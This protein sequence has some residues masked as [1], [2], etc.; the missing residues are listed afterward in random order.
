MVYLED[1]YYLNPLGINMQKLVV[2]FSFTLIFFGCTNAGTDK[3]TD[4]VGIGEIS[5]SADESLQPVVSAL[6]GAFENR[7]SAAKINVI[8]KPEQ[9]SINLLLLD[10]ARV[11]VVTRELNASEKKVFEQQ[12]LKYR[13]LKVGV[14]AVAL[15]TN[16]SSSDTLITFNQLKNMF[17]GKDKSK[18]LVVDDANSSN[19]VCVMDRLGLK[20]VTKL[21]VFSGQSNKGVIEYVKA[22][23]NAIGLIG[24]NWISDGD[25]PAS[26]GFYSDINVM[27]VSA[28]ENPKKE[29]YY[30]PFEYNLYLERYPFRRNIYMIT[31]EARQGLGTG[32][33]NF[34]ADDI[35]QLVIQKTGILPATQPLRLYKVQN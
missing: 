18:I 26:M 29:E 7:R 19:L 10:S 21:N 6:E 35:G 25:D 34:S 28:I 1:I 4:T 33:I 15:I 16:K 5:I 11:A 24:V 32:F 30:L 17:S 14:D 31:K 20:D 8:Y 13:S 2:L 3:N 22:N 23:R 9:E 12:K 27:S